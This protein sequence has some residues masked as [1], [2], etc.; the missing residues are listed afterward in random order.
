MTIPALRRGSPTPALAPTPH[1]RP[2]AR[3]TSAS[4]RSSI[5]G[6]VTTAISAPVAAREA[7][8]HSRR[9]GA[10]ELDSLF[11][12][13]RAPFNSYASATYR[14][15]KLR[16]SLAEVKSR[17]DSLPRNAPE[18]GQLYAVFGRLSDSVTVAQSHTEHARA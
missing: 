6:R 3:A 15:G 17:L 14:T 18:Y 12:A 4:D 2:M 10:A 5:V 7:K 8:S 9:P 11:Q 13:F 16:D 1:F